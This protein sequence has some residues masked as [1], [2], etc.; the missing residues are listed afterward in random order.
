MAMTGA[1]SGCAEA[2]PTNLQARGRCGRALPCR[3]INNSRPPLL[4]LATGE[5]LARGEAL[6]EIGVDGVRRYRMKSK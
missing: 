6:R 3:L 5:S 1:W 2:W 4:D